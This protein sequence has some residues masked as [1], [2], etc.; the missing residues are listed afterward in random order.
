ME[1][2][3]RELAEEQHEP[4]AIDLPDQPE[5]TDTVYITSADLPEMATLT[6]S[7]DHNT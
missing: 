6:L 4:E 3:T 5:S 1:R 7:G 2:D